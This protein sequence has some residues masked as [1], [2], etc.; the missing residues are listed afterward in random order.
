MLA[1]WFTGIRCN[2]WTSGKRSPFPLRFTISLAGTP[3]SVAQLKVVHG[4]PEVRGAPP[5]AETMADTR[6]ANAMVFMAIPPKT[7]RL[8]DRRKTLTRSSPA[9]REKM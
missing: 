1:G 8:K 7:A 6:N 9:P 3:V 5:V 4:S 2:D